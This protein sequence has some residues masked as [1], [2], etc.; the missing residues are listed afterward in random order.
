METKK[1]DIG[2]S[3]TWGDGPDVLV[4]LD[5]QAFICYEDPK[6]DPPPRGQ[7]VHGYVTKGSFDLTRNQALELAA[8]LFRAAGQA[9]DMDDSYAAHVKHEQAIHNAEV[10]H[11]ELHP[12]DTQDITNGDYLKKEE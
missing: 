1:L 6:N 5:G 10:E 4:T 12:E 3:C 9:K 8:Q 11:A 2:A 7:W